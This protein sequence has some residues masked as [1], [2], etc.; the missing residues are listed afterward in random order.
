MSGLALL[1]AV[2]LAGESPSVAPPA[3]RT[4]PEN[5]YFLH[6]GGRALDDDAF[7]DPVENMGVL[8]FEYVRNLTHDTP[9]GVGIEIGLFLAGDSD[10]SLGP[11]ITAGFLEASVGLRGRLD[12][13]PLQFSIGAGP[14]FILGAADIESGPDENDSSAGIYAHLGA[15][16]RIGDTFGL[17]LDARGLS[18]TD[19]TFDGIGDT[20][21]DY[22][23]VTIVLGF[24]P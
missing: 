2:A 11:E 10:D 23:Q 17:G 13:G 8:G 12:V 6:L 24:S 16:V 22:G 19:I 3:E 18:G 21:A 1:V 5:S 20:D 7:Y 14:A 9:A 15:L 4:V